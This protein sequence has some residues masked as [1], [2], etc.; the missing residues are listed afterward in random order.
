MKNLIV[1]ILVDLAIFLP[2]LIPMWIIEP[3]T[4]GNAAKYSIAA[5][6][7]IHMLA[8]LL[9]LSW[10]YCSRLIAKYLINNNL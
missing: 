1:F 5:D 6:Y 2:P 9:I 4:K 10:G 7:Y 3:I 8:F